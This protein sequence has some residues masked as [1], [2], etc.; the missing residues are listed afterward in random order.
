M[1]DVDELDQ[2]T[3]DE[4]WAMLTEFA[5]CPYPLKPFVGSRLLSNETFREDPRTTALL[6]ELRPG[7][8][9]DGVLHLGPALAS[10]LDMPRDSVWI[11]ACAASTRR[12]EISIIREANE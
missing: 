3:L 6:V 1:I 11:E 2:K 12:V 9:S 5:T 4:K 10:F 7:I 8:A